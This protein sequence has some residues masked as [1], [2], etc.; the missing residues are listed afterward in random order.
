MALMNWNESLSVNV[1][2]LDE[3]HKDLI[4]IINQIH[5]SVANGLGNETLVPLVA[6]LVRYTETHFADEERFM[7]SFNYPDLPAHTIEHRDIR[8]KVL[9]VRDRFNYSQAI[10]TGELMDFLLEWLVRHIRGADLKYAHAYVRHKL[11]I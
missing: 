5:E 10:L 3:Q 9:A 8:S 6:G 4:N 11:N 1:F 7:R 2:E